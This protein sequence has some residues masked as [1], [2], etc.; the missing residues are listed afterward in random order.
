MLNKITV[1]F[2]G[3]IFGNL[4]LEL[5]KVHLPKLKTQF[6][7][8]FI[9]ANGENSA[10]N[11]RGMGKQAAN[12]IFSVGVDCITLGN[13]T[14]RQ[15]D[16]YDVI[17]KEQRII[18]PANFPEGAPG[19]G[20]A[21]FSL[22]NYKIVVI[23]I[24]GRSFI[25][26]QLDC[27]FIKINNILAEIPEAIVIVDMHAETTSEKIALSWHLDGKVSAILGTH[28]HVQ[29]SDE[30]ILP[31]GTGYL[32]DVGM[33]GPYDGVI[34]L[35]PDGIIRRYLTQLPTKSVVAKGRGQFNAVLLEIDPLRRVTTSISR[36]RIND[37]HPF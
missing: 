32:T 15:Q 36:I 4:G 16:I 3:D 13:H 5:L 12:E 28:T 18:R 1:L 25:S 20:F 10:K 24:M 21:I 37:D 7:P 27:P 14:W 33:V 8:D 31:Q 9:I 26:P 30:R 2:I 35:E 29:T 6:R 23:N 17:E 11:G 22:S 19:R 34:G